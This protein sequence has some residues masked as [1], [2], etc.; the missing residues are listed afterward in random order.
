LFR[1]CSTGQYHIRDKTELSCGGQKEMRA[2]LGWIGEFISGGAKRYH[3]S[4][5][6]LEEVNF[7]SFEIALALR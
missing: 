4:C 3:D 1:N 5:L 7:K 6:G 2:G